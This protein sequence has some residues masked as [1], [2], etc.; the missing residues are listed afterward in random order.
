MKSI[1]Y[2][3]PERPT[4]SLLVISSRFLFVLLFLYM[5]LMISRVSLF[6]TSIY[7]LFLA[8]NVIIIII[9]ESLSLSNYYRTTTIISICL[10]VF[11]AYKSIKNFLISTYINYSGSGSSSVLILVVVVISQAFGRIG[12]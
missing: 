5:N 4:A 6:V 11:S 3:D 10:D 1:Q 9:W 12:L 8:H 7:D 2:P